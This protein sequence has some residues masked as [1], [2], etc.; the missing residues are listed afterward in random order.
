MHRFFGSGAASPPVN[1]V[2]RQAL[3]VEA[4]VLAVCKRG[5]AHG[6]GARIIGFLNDAAGGEQLHAGDGISLHGVFE[7][8]VQRFHGGVQHAQLPARGH[9]VRLCAAVAPQPGQQYT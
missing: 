1:Q 6:E 9:D 4:P 5:E 7:V 3:P 2:P 8:G